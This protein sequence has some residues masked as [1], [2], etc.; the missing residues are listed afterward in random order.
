V[1]E[2]KHG[3]SAFIDPSGG[4]LDAMTLAIIHKEG[5]TENPRSDS[6]ATAMAANGRSSNLPNAE[7]TSNRQRSPSQISTST[8]FH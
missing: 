7:S 5:E 6:T 2:F 3:Y 8:W 4:S 1:P